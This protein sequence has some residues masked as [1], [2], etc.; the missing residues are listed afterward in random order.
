MKLSSSLKLS[1]L[2]LLSTAVL[3]AAPLSS[4]A[5]DD[6]MAGS[7]P[8]AKEA[9]KV[10]ESK[11][12]VKEDEKKAEKEPE[13]KAEEKADDIV[14]SD[15]E[16]V[17]AE[18][19]EKPA[20]KTPEEKEAEKKAEKKS[21]AARTVVKM[22]EQPR[23]A[24]PKNVDLNALE[25]FGLL[26]T[27]TDGAL[28]IDMWDGS[29]YATVSK[30][31]SDVP[32]LTPYHAIND[33]QRRVLLTG[34][35]IALATGSRN[36]ENG[37][38]V[39]TLRIE[40]LNQMGLFAEAGSLY[41]N[42][43][44]EPYGE[45]LAHAGVTALLDSGKTAQACLEILSVADRFTDTSFWG[46]A[47]AVCR[48]ISGKKDAAVES[49][50][51]K[52]VLSDLKFRYHPA[53]AEDIESLTALERGFLF[54][55]RRVAYDKFRP[56]QSKSLKSEVLALLLSDPD[57]PDYFRL[58]FMTMAVEQGVKA[59]SDL[60]V[61]YETHDGALPALYKKA[62]ATEDKDARA[63]VLAQV[64]NTDSSN[65]FARLS[66]F[67]DML[68]ES[69]PK[70]FSTASLQK[71]LAVMAWS[72]VSIPQNWVESLGKYDN[73][74]NNKTMF[75]ALSVLGMGRNPPIDDAVHQ[76]W[77]DYAAKAP[78][79]LEDHAFRVMYETFD[80]HEPA[81]DETKIDGYEK[82][83]D[84]TADSG[85]VMPTGGFL[86]DLNAAAKKRRVGEVVLLSSSGLRDTPSGKLH[87][88]TF[89]AVLDGLLSVGLTNEAR[90]FAVEVM[91]GLN[92][93]KEN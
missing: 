72:G 93:T 24:D 18:A 52:N 46:Q 2:L 1:A 12:D 87:P 42:N 17:T 74:A 50:I 35:D 73:S 9:V 84:L 86:D 92:E 27:A 38:D 83:V 41:A 51:L 60:K 14:K 8:V 55:L 37:G 89:R 31:L 5:E 82:N 40:K 43:P 39:L 29:S 70:K 25:S 36:R 66:P 90:Q 32:D 68:A 48:A 88:R 65:D 69:S 10:E 78:E 80:K 63:D 53:S 81:A 15:E 3:T 76:I 13:K 79:S 61:L 21:E 4:R 75:L 91:L 57:L 7:V 33:L 45:R 23:L 44:D 34:G 58:P 71:A 11:T 16:K 20:E 67:A 54:G 77:A 62:A 64:L 6:R 56:G 30:L 85:Y 28:G 59:P 47:Q 19:V 49:E 26:T 22:P